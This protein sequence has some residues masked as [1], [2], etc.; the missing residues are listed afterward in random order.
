M[1]HS[2]LW[3]RCARWWRF[4]FDCPFGR[5]E[6]RDRQ[7]VR[8]RPT[9]P[10]KFEQEEEHG[11]MVRKSMEE[12]VNEVLEAMA[13]E[14]FRGSPGI[15]PPGP[16]LP[17]LFPPFPIPPM[18]RPDPHEPAPARVPALATAA[19]VRGFRAARGLNPAAIERELTQFASERV[20]KAIKGRGIDFSSGRVK[21]V[22]I[23][24][25]VAGGGFLFDFA[26]RMKFRGTPGAPLPGSPGGGGGSGSQL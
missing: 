14:A 13:E 9:P 4:G 22:A 25:A 16:V 21:A 20:R 26:R 23:G 8:V 6:E 1:S 19:M 12:M 5:E 7:R 3:H 18:R 24:G 10:F 11:Q 17:P 15:N 2:V